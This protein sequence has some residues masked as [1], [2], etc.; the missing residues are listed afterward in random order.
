MFL[1][2]VLALDLED[3]LLEGIGPPEIVYVLAVVG[4]ADAHVRTAEGHVGEL[5]DDLTQ[6]R[7]VRLEELAPGREAVED[8][9]DGYV[10][11]LGH[12]RLLLGDKAGGSED[13][14]GSGLGA[15]PAGTE[16]NLGHR[17]DGGQGLPAETV[18]QDRVQVGGLRYLG[19]SMSLEAEPRLLRSHAA[20]VVD[21]LDQGLARIL[22]DDADRAGSGV[23]GIFQKFL[24]DRGRALDHFPGGYEVGYVG[25]Q[26]PKHR[27]LLSYALQDYSRVFGEKVQKRQEGG[28]RHQSYDTGE[29]LAERAAS[30][31]AGLFLE[32]AADI[33]A[34]PVGLV[35]PLPALPEGLLAER[36]V[37]DHLAA[38]LPLVPVAGLV[39][40]HTVIGDF[41]KTYTHRLSSLMLQLTKV[42]KIYLTCNSHFRPSHL[43]SGSSY[44]FRTM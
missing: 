13:C 27:I 35:L 18:G 26:N 44:T 33:H 10:G 28:D 37:L 23:N 21:H 8:V 29:I 32:L 36:L 16:R 4:Q 15:F 41:E 38:F 22:D 39:V 43:R 17:R 11:P 2:H 31:V 30:V 34:G 19:G 24:D 3:A 42:D 20:A 40:E 7:I 1:A 12:G 9:A 6:L 14:L 25:R 5:G